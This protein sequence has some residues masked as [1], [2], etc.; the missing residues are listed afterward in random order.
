[1]VLNKLLGL[2]GKDMAMD[3]GTA[4]TLIFIKG[5]G[6]VLNEPSAVAV[7]RQNGKPVAVGK[8]AKEYLGRTNPSILASRPL[9]DGVIADFDLTRVM[10]RQFIT[11]VRSATRLVKPRMLI[12]VPTGVT[13]V[14]KRAVIESAEQAGAREIFLIEEPMA[15]AIGAGLPIDKPQGSMVVDIGGGTT[16]VAVISMFAT[17]YSESVRVAGD[18]ANE[19]V[20]R[21]A[22]KKYQMLIGENTAEMVKIR[23]GSAAPLDQ[24][25]SMEVSGK[26]LVQG[27]PRTVTMNDEE[28]REALAEPVEVIVESVRRAFEK[29]PPELASDVAEQGLVLAG[30]GALIRGLD[31]RISEELNMRVRIA[32]DPLISVVMGAGI[33]LQNIREYR[34]VFLN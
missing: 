23:I 26:D 19:A 10:I 33:A 3:L 14:E 11:K 31:R 21:L 34:R 27:I 1:M 20:M 6:V 24:P 13:Q 28:V 15:A 8:E 12:G 18:E 5:R 4:N 17:A 2:C 22:Q 16:E 32:E 7:Q 9:K 30:G 25:L 29:T